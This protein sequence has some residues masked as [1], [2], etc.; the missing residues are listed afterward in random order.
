LQDTLSRI[1]LQLNEISQQRDAL[2]VQHESREAEFAR[3]KA[4]LED[5]LTD[6]QGAD[7]RAQESQVT[8]QQGL[9]AEA[10]RTR[11]RQCADILKSGLTVRFAGSAAEVSRSLG[12]PCGYS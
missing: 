7:K 9:L 4:L 3:E 5:L 10:Q 6:V 11:V 1:Q 12:R 2:Q 8:A